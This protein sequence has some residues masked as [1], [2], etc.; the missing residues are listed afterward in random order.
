MSYS[1]VFIDAIGYELAPV[2]V[3]SAELEARLRPVYEKLRMAGGTAR[4]R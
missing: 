2:V 1:H 4:R 3:T